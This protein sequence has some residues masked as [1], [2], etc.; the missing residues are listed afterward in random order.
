MK[1]YLGKVELVSETVIQLSDWYFLSSPYKCYH[2]LHFKNKLEKL[3]ELASTESEPYLPDLVIMN[4]EA[5]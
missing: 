4:A 3:Q 2:T 1:I 5:F